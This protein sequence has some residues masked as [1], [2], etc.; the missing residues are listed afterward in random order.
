MTARTMKSKR[1]ENEMGL[2][3]GL[4]GGSAII[5][6]RGLRGLGACGF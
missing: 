1:T 4:L 2:L 6:I 5:E 3:R